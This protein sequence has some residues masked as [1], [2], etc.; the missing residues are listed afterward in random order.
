MSDKRKQLTNAA[1]KAVQLGGLQSLSFRNLAES[2]GIKSSSVHYH[3]PEKSDLAKALL[4]EY[5]TEFFT[6]LAEL[7]SQ[8]SGLKAKLTAVIGIFETL[9]SNDRLCLCGMMAAE[10]EQ[11]SSDN[12]LLLNEFFVDL[13]QW[14]VDLLSAYPD[15]ISSTL[16]TRKLARAFISGLEGSLLLDRVGGG[17]RHVKAQKDL[18]LSMID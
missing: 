4:D 3:F 13:E 12:K 5:R 9:A 10:V 11:L 16:P 2:V 7:A 1:T 18:I 8:R 17:T 14:L 15:D 6:R